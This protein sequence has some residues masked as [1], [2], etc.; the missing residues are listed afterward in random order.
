MRLGYFAMPMHFEHRSW[1]DTLREDREAVIL[2]DE[3][4]YHDCFIGEHLTDKSENI[5]NSMLFLA[6]LISDTRQIRLGTGTSNLSHSHPVLIASQAA[7]FDHLAGGRFIFG[8]SPGALSCDAEV[9]GIL[10][11]DRGKLF[12]EAIDVILEIWSSDPP[13][14]IHLPDNRFH[15]STLQTEFPEVGVGFLQKPLQRPRPEI[16][17][18]VVAPYSKGVIAMG[19]RDFHPLSAHFL[20]P[21]W[22]KTHWPNYVRGKQSV[23][24]S[25]DP[26][27]WRVARTIFV[28][29]DGR[30]AREYGRT[31]SRS[32]YVFFYDH[33][34]AKLKRAGR[35]DVFK[36]RS[37]QSD[38][39]VDMGAICD[40]L[41]IYGTVDKVVDEILALREEVGHF[42]E[43]VYGGVDWVDP[44]LSRRS[45]VLMAEQVMPRVNEAIGSSQA[46]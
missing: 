22:L 39:D 9:L 26:D 41:I 25:A 42:G 18:T 40:R 20:L 38:G 32:P 2:A 30:I 8:I 28:A 24:A 36:D 19:A 45:M 6:S 33:L 11:E 12:A 13:Y 37:E 43:L 16:V 29:D 17:G 31:N 10:D 23:G 7:M 44:A 4:G 27:D 14:D 35:F 46:A 1:S 3:L 21:K 34:G 5:T 15:V